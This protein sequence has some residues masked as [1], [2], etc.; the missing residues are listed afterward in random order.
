MRCVTMPEQWD[1]ALDEFNTAFG[2]SASCMFSIHEFEENRADFTWSRFF[3]NKR[4]DG[5]EAFMQAG[6]D[7]DDR[8]AY[9][10]LFRFPPQTFYTEMVTFGV[11]D[12]A[13]LPPS[14]VRDL[15][16]RWG[17]VMRTAAAVNSNGPWVDTLLC[18][19]R[20]C[21]QWQ[22]LL[23]NRD[24]QIAF[25]ILANALSLGRT[26]RALRSR[27]NA[28]LSVLDALGLGV[29][30]IDARHNVI[31]L[32][33]AA[34]HILDAADGIRLNSKRQ[35]M[36][37]TH[38]EEQELRALTDAANGLLKGEVNQHETVMSVRRQS[39]RYDYLISVQPLNDAA[40]ELEVGLRCAFVT[41]IDPGKDGAL[42][43]DGLTAL[44]KLTPT[45]ADIVRLLVEGRRLREIAERRNVSINTIKTQLKDVVQKLR[46]STQ[47]DVIR[48]A[49]ATRVPVR[50]HP[51]G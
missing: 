50:H 45:E 6:A 42:S 43:I 20:D 17:F 21:D 2:I 26:V 19:H 41:V 1:Y 32:N 27:F 44:G 22:K 24:V 18:Q 49:A 34:Q 39:G 3:R 7:A 40:A 23:A 38:E 47:S 13:D 5:V 10:N 4:H 25:P 48:M 36:L 28:A 29:F 35:M 51:N 9:K 31:D 11:A 16:E 33:D 14:K 8:P 30:L 15:T 12:Y 37:S 46:C